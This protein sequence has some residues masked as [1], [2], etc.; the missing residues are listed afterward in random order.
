MVGLSARREM[1]THLEQEYQVSQ[2]RSCKVLGLARSTHRRQTGR[3][4]VDL[5]KRLIELS[6]KYPRFGYRKVWKLL[7]KEGFTISRERTRLLR[8][9]EGLQVRKKAKKQRRSGSSTGLPTQAT[10]GNHVWSYDFVADQTIDGR[11][12]RCLTVIDEFTRQCLVIEISRSLTAADVKRVL[13]VLFEIYGQPSY[14]RSDNGAEFT[15]RSITDWLKQETKVKTLFIDP[16]SPWQN[17][18][19]ESFNGIFRDSCLNCWGFESIREA[20]EITDN[21]IYEYNYIRPHGSLN[22]MTPIEF[23][24]SHQNEVKQ[25][26]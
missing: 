8:R 24:A 18:F 6:H 7:V 10:H 11:R 12:L 26:A 9:Q 4:D 21:W 3:R 19:N 16:G 2:R 20:R 22:L 25:A 23:I 17:G 15:A 14:I 13:T 5:I 1:A